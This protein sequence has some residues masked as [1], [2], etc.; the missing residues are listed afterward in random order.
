MAARI[1]GQKKRSTR[2]AAPRKTATRG[3]SRKKS[4]A[5]RATKPAK[6]ATA[7][8]KAAGGA[9]ESAGEVQQKGAATVEETM[10]QLT[11]TPTRRKK[12][13]QADR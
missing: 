9:M 11:G 2:K 3:T 1:T 10:N 7:R 8:A 5:P 12:S 4:A 13:S 6:P